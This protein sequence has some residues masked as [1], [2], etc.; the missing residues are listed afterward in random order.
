M[1]AQNR[2]RGSGSSPTPMRRRPDPVPG[3]TPQPSPAGAHVADLLERAAVGH[4]LQISVSALPA[5]RASMIR[6]RV[7]SGGINLDI[8]SQA[9]AGPIMLVDTS[10]GLSWA[11]N[12][13]GPRSEPRV[14]HL[15]PS[16]I[17]E[18]ILRTLS[19]SKP[20][21]RTHTGQRT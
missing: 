2:V 10:S 21:D 20:K 9:P 6:L 11:L 13:P 12:C 4:G 15:T 16:E 17:V 18:N 8:S 7:C 5:P 19:D 1:S 14:L 3:T